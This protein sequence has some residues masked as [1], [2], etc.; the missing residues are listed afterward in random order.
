M[1]TSNP[2]VGHFTFPRRVEQIGVFVPARPRVT[3]IKC[4]IK[5]H[6][7][8]A[9]IAT[10]VIDW[11]CLPPPKPEHTLHGADTDGSRGFHTYARKAPVFAAVLCAK[12][13]EA[14]VRDTRNE[15]KRDHVFSSEPAL[16]NKGFHP[17]RRREKKTGRTNS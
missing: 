6:Y 10:R 9:C 11:L 3:D 14:S 17:F 5:I 4:I 13:L 7:A 1:P 12:A 8:T 16:S 2:I 15:K